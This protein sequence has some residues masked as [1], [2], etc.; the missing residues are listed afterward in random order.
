MK[1]TNIAVYTRE[2]EGFVSSDFKLG[3]IE[4]GKHLD[5]GRSLG[6]LDVNADYALQLL[7]RADSAFPGGR[8]PLYVCECCAD[9]GCG[10]LTVKVEQ[11]GEKVVWRDFGYQEPE[12]E[13]ISQSDYLKRT[14]PFEFNQAEYVSAIKPYSVRSHVV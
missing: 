13:N 7:G 11:V 1:T 3:N 4:L 10:A 2:F 6:V 5:V 9:L 8:V 14:G 12:D